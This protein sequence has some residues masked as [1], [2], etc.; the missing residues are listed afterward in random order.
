M[1][2]D[3]PWLNVPQAVVLEATGDIELGLDLTADNPILLVIKANQLIARQTVI[4]LAEDADQARRAE[5][6]RKLR[7][8]LMGKQDDGRYAEAERRLR[9]RV[10]AGVRTKASRTPGGAY[11]N[12]DPVEYTRA[13]FQGVDAIDKRTQKIILFDV[14]ISCIDLINSLAETAI[15]RSGIGSSDAL[16]QPHALQELEKWDHAGDPVPK[17][18]DW[19]RS[20]WGKDVQKLPNRDALLQAFRGQFGRVFGI[21]QNTMREVRRQLAPREARRGGAP[22]HRRSG[23][24]GN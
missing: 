17:L 18:I 4:P 16:A 14:R 3:D 10:V 12:V 7:E 9:R 5:A 21:N 24:A 22:M 19:A 8:A 6:F 13:E 23:V 20:R 2:D 1:I 11:E 15:T